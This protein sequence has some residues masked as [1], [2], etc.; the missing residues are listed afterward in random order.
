MEGVGDDHRIQGKR[1]GTRGFFSR[2]S[3]CLGREASLLALVEQLQGQGE[4]TEQASL[5]KVRPSPA[6]RRVWEALP[7]SIYPKET[8]CY[9]R[10]P[11]ALG[12]GPWGGSGVASPGA[13]AGGRA[14]MPACQGHSP[15]LQP[16]LSPAE[17]SGTT[18]NGP[19]PC[20]PSMTQCG[21]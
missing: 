5:W 21:L 6:H 11:G 18:G 8:G 20:G 7:A 1:G 19:W 13:G 2:G 17:S 4:G 12:P 16:G 15:L 10:D 14:A 9:C 3:L